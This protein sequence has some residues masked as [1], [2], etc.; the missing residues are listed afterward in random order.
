MSGKS[1]PQGMCVLRMVCIEVLSDYLSEDISTCTFEDLAAYLKVAWKAPA[2]WLWV[3]C[4]IKSTFKAH[5][6]IRDA[7]E[8]D[9]HL[10]QDCL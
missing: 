1:W 4:V 5:L 6:F 7:R 10:H 9:W 2:G 8:G 3:D